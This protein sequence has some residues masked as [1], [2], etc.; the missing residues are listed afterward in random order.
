MKEEKINLERVHEEESEA[1]VNRLARELAVLRLRQHQQLQQANGAE[2][3]KGKRSTAGPS[4]SPQV[5]GTLFS[6][7]STDVL[8]TALQKENESLRSRLASTEQEFI[9]LTRLNEIYREELIQHRRRVCYSI[10]FIM[11]KR[12]SEV[13]KRYIHL[14]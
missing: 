2:D 8:L 13:N 3:D 5:S 12:V 6:D 14:A 4:T 10:F 1:Q 11:N 7:P 9:R